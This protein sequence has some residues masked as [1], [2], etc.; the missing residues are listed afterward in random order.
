MICYT[1]YFAI[2][3]YRH[4]RAEQ[5]YGDVVQN[6]IIT[7]ENEEEEVLVLDIHRHNTVT[8]HP[9]MVDGNTRSVVSTDG[10]D[11]KDEYRFE[12]VY[13]VSFITL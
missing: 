10:K 13:S 2:G 7:L 11:G 8:P 1:F 3:R 9:K 6:T 5:G 12:K 4:V